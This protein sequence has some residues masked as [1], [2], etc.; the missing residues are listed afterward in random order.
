MRLATRQFLALLFQLPPRLTRLEALTDFTRISP[1]LKQWSFFETPKE[2]VSQIPCII[3]AQM[4]D[5]AVGTLQKSLLFDR[6]LLKGLFL[7]FEPV[8]TSFQIRVVNAY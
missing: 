2:F 5:D 4:G 6:A 3:L 8:E 7:F 1:A